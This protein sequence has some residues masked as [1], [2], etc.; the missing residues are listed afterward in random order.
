MGGERKRFKKLNQRTKRFRRRLTMHIYVL[1]NLLTTMN[2][3][4]GFFAIIYAIKGNFPYAAY[5][6]VAAAV[7]DLL[8][9]RVARL[10]HST[11][12]FGAEYDSLCDLV[13]FG[14]APS[15]LLF[16]WALQPFGRIGWLAAF[17]F[18][19]C[20]ALRLA[21]F[22]VQQDIIE[23][24]Y[25][26]GLPIPMAAGIV[27]SSVLAFQDLELVAYRSPWLLAM[28]F[29]LGF[30]MVSTFRYRSFK[31]IDLKQRLPFTY[32][33]LGVFMLALIA[34][35]PEVMLFVLFLTYA[36]LGAVFGIL[37]LGRPIKKR[38]PEFEEDDPYAEEDDLH[39]EVE[40]DL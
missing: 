9:G 38:L 8:D 18:V 3:F 25:F 35:R 12:E 4:F 15:L 17:F 24:A 16:L 30:V 36:I 10:T 26:Q 37:R 39:E 13:S 28:T 2:M 19:A 31:D 29:L 32:L 22:N 27:A 40:E 23:K 11:S 1:P 33:V 7:F 14:I 34:I 6:I 21:R 20:G 5:A